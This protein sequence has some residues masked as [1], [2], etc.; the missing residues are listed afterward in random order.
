MPSLKCYAPC[1]FMQLCIIAC[2]N[3]RILAEPADILCASEVEREDDNVP[4]K[5]EFADPAEPRKDDL[6]RS[7]RE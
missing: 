2:P 4:L 1:G 7:T 5:I 3:N 6:D